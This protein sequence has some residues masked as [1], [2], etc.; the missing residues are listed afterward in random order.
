MTIN[1]YLAHFITPECSLIHR[2]T[3]P[4]HAPTDYTF[5]HSAK[6]HINA[7]AKLGSEYPFTAMNQLDLMTPRE[8]DR[9]LRGN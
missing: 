2:A 8:L 6:V 4:H 9:H 7:F 5:S 3:K 1:A